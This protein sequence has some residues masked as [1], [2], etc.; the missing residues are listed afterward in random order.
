MSDARKRFIE[1]HMTKFNPAQMVTADEHLIF[2][3]SGGVAQ[4]PDS[5]YTQVLAPSFAGIAANG[6]P[7]VKR[8]LQPL[9]RGVGAGGYSP[10]PAFANRTYSLTGRRSIVINMAKS[11]GYGAEVEARTPTRHHDARFIETSMLGPIVDDGVLRSELLPACR[12]LY[13]AA[14]GWTVQHR[15][16]WFFGQEGEAVAYGNSNID[17]DRFI[18][19]ANEF[20]EYMQTEHGCH[21]LFL[22][23]TMHR[24]TTPAEMAAHNVPPAGQTWVREA[25]DAAEAQNDNIHVVNRWMAEDADSEGTFNSIEIGE[26]WDHIAGTASYDGDHPSDQT[27]LAWGVGAG[28]AYSAIVGSV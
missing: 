22:S 27:Q 15:N 4:S 7:G 10:W 28:E 8:F 12:A 11:L 26:G 20:L 23:Y 19:W 9:Q 21:R 18:A 2:G 24:G 1:Q 6:L 3:N 16:V 17:T 25:M 5:N 13:E 14:P